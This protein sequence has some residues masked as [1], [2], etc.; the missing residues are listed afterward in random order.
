MR[1][2]YQYYLHGERGRAGLAA[3]RREFCRVLWRL[4][5]PTW[6]FAETLYAQ[7]AASFENADFVAVVV[8]SYRH[9]FGLTPGD[10]AVADSER[11]LAV[12]P[13]IAVPSIAL[14]GTGDGVTP[15]GSYSRLDHL[16]VNGLQRQALPQVGHNLPQVA[17]QEF[18]AAVLEVA[19]RS[20]PTEHLIE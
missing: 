1:D 20:Q 17:P 15:P 4:W 19:R 16:F 11:R 18:A 9:R 5:S 14:E 3:Y 8:H 6:Q 12:S 2:W 13:A 7:T 10:P